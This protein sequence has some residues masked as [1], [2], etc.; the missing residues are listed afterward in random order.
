MNNHETVIVRKP[1]GYEYLAYKNKAVALWVLHINARER[2]SMHCHPSKTTGLV[3]VGGEAEINFISDSKILQAPAKQMIRRGL[4][5]Q[6]CALEKDVIL[7]ELETPIDK[8]DLVRLKDQYGRKNLGYEKKDF[9]L[10]KTDECLWIE[11][12]EG[13]Q[14]K[15]YFIGNSVVRVLNLT[16][17]EIL[18]KENDTNIIV[19]LQGGLIKTIDGRKHMV[20]APGDVGVANVVK[21]VMKEMDGFEEDTVVLI[22]NE[23]KFNQC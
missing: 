11:D 20:I 22:I 6:T 8:D 3:L 14:T 16:D 2:T 23:Q 10:P 4:F 17:K 13:H 9:E 18:E 1:W 19:F 12:P 5:H 21:Q 15:K 7:F